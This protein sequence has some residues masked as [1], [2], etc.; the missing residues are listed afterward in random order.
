VLAKWVR[1]HFFLIAGRLVSKG[2]RLILRLSQGYPWKEEYQRAE[3]RLEALKL[4][5]PT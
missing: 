1:Q 5:L 2:R 3:A 4:P